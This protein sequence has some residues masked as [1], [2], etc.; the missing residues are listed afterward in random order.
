MYSEKTCPSAILSITDPTRP[1]LGLNPRHRGGKPATSHLS[2]DTALY[3]MLL[4]IL[5]GLLVVAALSDLVVC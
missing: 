2:Y 4:M 1:D 3:M 5:F